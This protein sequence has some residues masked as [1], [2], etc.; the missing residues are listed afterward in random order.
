ME[1]KEIIAVVAGEEVTSEQF[2]VF[3]KTLPQEQQMYISNPQFRESIKDQFLSLFAYAKYAEDM[4]LDETD[5]FKTAMENARREVLA[6]MAIAETLKDITVEEQEV[7]DF[8]EA[9]SYHFQNGPTVN[10]KHILVEDEAKCLDIF[11]AINDGEVTFEAEAKEHST[12]PSGAEG[13]SLGYF[14][15]G[16]MVKEFEEAAFAAEIGSIVGPVKTQFGYH[17]IKVEDKKESSVIPFEEVK[18]RIRQMLLPQKQ[19]QVYSA[20]YQELK[21]KYVK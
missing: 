11:R 19:N 4:K 6:N 9:Q 2:D 1:N 21:E 8:Y 5:A 17:L 10:A 14:G 20:K 16:Q 7:K 3:L 12:C 13:G 15:K 18:D